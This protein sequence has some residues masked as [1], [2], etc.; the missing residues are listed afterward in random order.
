[1]T[2][3]KESWKK[4]GSDFGDVGRDIGKSELGK[5]LG[6]L[7]KDFGKSIVKSVKHGVKAVS[8]WADKDDPEEEK[9]EAPAEEGEVI[10][11]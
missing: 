9:E 3:V 11:E 1:M 10:D 8:D 2:S 4:V 7:G 5:D 6:K